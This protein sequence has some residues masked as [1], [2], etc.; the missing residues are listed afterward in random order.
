MLVPQLDSKGRV[1]GSLEYDVLVP[2]FDRWRL[3]GEQFNLLTEEEGQS[4]VAWVNAKEP[5]RAGYV[6]TLLQDAGGPVEGLPQG[7]EAFEVFSAWLDLWVKEVYTAWRRGSWEVAPGGLPEGL[8]H[9]GGA[10]EEDAALLSL[11]HD[12]AFLVV[13][14]AR[15]ARPELHWALSRSPLGVRVGPNEPQPRQHLPTI[16]P[17][18]EST[19]AISG[20]AKMLSGA[21]RLP[22]AD[23]KV[24]PFLGTKPELR[25]HVL[26]REEKLRSSRRLLLAKLY[27]ALVHG[28][29]LH[30]PGLVAGVL[31]DQVLPGPATDEPGHAGAKRPL[32]GLLGEPPGE[33]A[34]AIESYLQAGWFQSRAGM[35]A[36]VLARQL[37]GEWHRIAGVDILEGA[38]EGVLDHR[39]LVLDAERT[40]YD[41]IE[42]GVGPSAGVYADMVRALAERSDGV[43]KPD[44]LAED[45]DSRPG[46]VVVH[47]RDGGRH[48]DL[49]VVDCGDCIAPA[50][51]SEVNLALPAGGPRV[52]FVDNGGQSAIVTRA[53]PEERDR[54]QSLRPVRLDEQA[55]PWWASVRQVASRGP[56]GPAD[57]HRQL[58]GS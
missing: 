19:L 32:S 35:P 42:A 36:E 3:I 5:E 14:F 28:T 49:V 8:F 52:W 13:S 15:S 24:A 34:G 26:E 44:R 45:W 22:L 41:D 50:I 43:F 27:R 4:Y 6:C 39:L 56:D 25:Q 7:L 16:L 47:C 33:V 48:L 23:P 31:P 40:W 17:G 12:V 51:V 11:A 9:S 57:R 1:A 2:P 10:G 21:L 29:A 55:P 54:L 18:A 53:T 37:L 58:D 20:V 30:E 38:K 46:E